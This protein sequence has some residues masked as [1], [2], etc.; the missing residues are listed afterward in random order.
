MTKKEYITEEDARCIMKREF[1]D[2]ILILVAVAVGLSIACFIFFLSDYIPFKTSVVGTFEE[3][4][5]ECIEYET[6]KQL[7]VSVACFDLEFYV[8]DVTYE[9]FKNWDIGLCG[10]LAHYS[11]GIRVKEIE[12]LF[13]EEDVKGDCKTYT[14]RRHD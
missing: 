8:E 14:L 12:P 11:T 10:Q 2:L 13:Y 7:F 1:P 3:T 5:W 9:E 4:Y 6:E